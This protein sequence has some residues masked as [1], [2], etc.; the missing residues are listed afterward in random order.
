MKSKSR[1]STSSWLQSL[2]PYE[3]RLPVDLR[4]EFTVMLRSD[5]L[6][7][8]RDD[9][10]PTAY[11]DGIRGLAAFLVVIHHWSDN[12]HN[13]GNYGYGQTPEDY[14]WVK[15]PFVRL[16]FSSGHSMVCIFFIVSGF[17][18]AYR[19]IDY[20]N[21]RRYDAL[22]KN[23]SSSIVRRL[24]R[25]MLPALAICVVTFWLIRF[26]FYDKRLMYFPA[27]ERKATLLE[28]I[29]DWWHDVLYLADPYSWDFVIW[30]K[31]QPHTWTLNVELHGSLWVYMMLIFIARLRKDARHYFLLGWTAYCVYRLKPWVA[32]FAFGVWMADHQYGREEETSLWDTPMLVL[33][34]F[35]MSCPVDGHQANALGWGYIWKFL[36]LWIPDGGKTTFQAI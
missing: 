31:Y 35:L 7:K 2:E 33:G 5:S 28:Q 8:R 27:F 15:L 26:G 18:L 32:L 30:T 4:P 19:P 25:L 10:R 21:T 14:D 6:L 13:R 24:P 22:L 3:K 23:I 12:V 9:L 16:L 20:I 1:R 36:E 11:L 34:G 17:A 29:Y